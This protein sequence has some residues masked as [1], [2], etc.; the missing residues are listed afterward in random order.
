MMGEALSGKLSCMWTDH[1]VSL[2]NW[3]STLFFKIRVFI[4]QESRLGVLNNSFPCNYSHSNVHVHVSKCTT[5]HPKQEF[6]S[7]VELKWLEH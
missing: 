4:L 7:T 1:V 2:F 6:L 5:L 3:G